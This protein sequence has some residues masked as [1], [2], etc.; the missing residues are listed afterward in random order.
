MI[1]PLIISI[2]FITMFYLEVTLMSVPF[3]LCG[4][5]LLF[6]F[7]KKTYVFALA[8]IFGIMLDSLLLR[9]L[10]STS[11]FLL[12]F[13]VVVLLYDR[14]FEVI[15]YPF[16]LIIT[17]IGN[18]IYAIYFNTPSLFGQ[19]II[20]QITVTVGYFIF[21]KLNEKKVS[22]SFKRI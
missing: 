16:L 22:T 17:T 13:L 7:T 3:I 6:V 10:G 15:S 12:L 11:I 2:I 8:F 5:L 19:L 1:R 14:K 4:L 18:I 21:K 9:T 20:T